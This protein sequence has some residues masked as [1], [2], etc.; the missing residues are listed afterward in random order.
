MSDSSMPEDRLSSNR[1]QRIAALRTI[2]ELA[3]LTS[4]EF[5]WI[6]DAGSE[7]SAQDGELIFSQGSPPSHLLFVLSGEI[8]I[9]RHTSSP[10]TVFSGGTGRITGKTPF[11]RMRS[12]NADG[13]ASGNVW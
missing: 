5:Q 3:G 9:K 13:R 6:A 12:W 2:E 10:V 8:T 11:S 4:E 1:E 7:R